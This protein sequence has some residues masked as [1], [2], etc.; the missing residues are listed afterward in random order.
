MLAYSLKK[1]VQ[2]FITTL[3]VVTL[4]FFTLRLIPGDAASAMA[5][6]SLSGEALE[7]L[8]EQMGLTKPYLVQ[9]LTY[10]KGLASLDFGET[11]TTGLSVFGLMKSA[12]PITLI[13]A[14][15][16]IVF[17]VLVSIPLGTL[18]AFMAH[19]GHKGL[20]NAIT[21][22]AMVLDL[23]PGF[24]TGLVFLLFFSLKLRWFPASG[25]VN[26]A[27]P[28]SFLQRIALP[29]LVLSVTQ[30]ATMARITRTAVLEV[31]GE[32]YIRTAR[33]LGWSEL[34]V[35][36]RHALKNAALPIVTVVGLSFGS[37]LNGTV[38]V[39][40]IFNIPGIGSLLVNGINSRDYQMV[41][42]LIIF[43]ALI[44]V[45]INFITD[46]VYRKLDPR[47]KF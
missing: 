28:A 13:I 21:G 1:L 34:R 29:V 14:I 30:I 16:T 47:V 4:V 45:S 37:L 46:L 25:D 41:Q 11:I 20:D 17:T 40:F 38:I 3:G 12:L 9:Y 36:F 27:D 39:E 5:G 23:M 18:A 26:I 2:L 19:K 32:D 6:D 31:L 15:S 24:W 33:S 43:Y 8:R 35:L 10:L 42:N 7:R 22:T 44:F